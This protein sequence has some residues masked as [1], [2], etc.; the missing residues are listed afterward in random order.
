V[1]V[2]RLIFVFLP[3]ESLSVKVPNR[4]EQD[5]LHDKG[6]WE[7]KFPLDILSTQEYTYFDFLSDPK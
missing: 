4:S 6:F 5:C 3:P 7:G 2:E 1:G